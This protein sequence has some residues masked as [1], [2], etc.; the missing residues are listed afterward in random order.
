MGLCKP[1]AILTM[2]SRTE[3]VGLRIVKKARAAEYATLQRAGIPLRCW[4]RWRDFEGGGKL[5][6]AVGKLGYGLLPLLDVG[7]FVVEELGDDLDEGVGLGDI[8]VGEAGSG[9]VEDGAL[10]DLEDDVVARIALV[11]LGLDFAVEVVFL[12]LGLPV[13]VG[14]M[15]GVE[16]S[17]VDADGGSPTCAGPVR[18]EP[19]AGKS[20]PS[21]TLPFQ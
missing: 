10:G 15:E 3:G 12:A 20:D 9:L 5:R 4:R 14:E 13:A 17:A 21:T 1:S 8:L 7:S 6:N 19:E 16:E 18:L 2:S 11:E